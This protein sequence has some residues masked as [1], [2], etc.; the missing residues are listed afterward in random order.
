MI[1]FIC[2]SQTGLHW[3]FVLGFACFIFYYLVI[4]S[5]QHLM[6]SAPFEM[7]D[8]DESCTDAKFQQKIKESVNRMIDVIYTCTFTMWAGMLLFNGTNDVVSHAYLYVLSCG[9]FVY[10]TFDQYRKL[11]ICFA[12]NCSGTSGLWL[13]VLR[14]IIGALMTYMCL[15]MLTVE[16]GGWKESILSMMVEMTASE[17]WNND[18]QHKQALCKHLLNR[19][20]KVTHLMTLFLLLLTVSWVCHAYRRLVQYTTLNKCDFVCDPGKYICEYKNTACLESMNCIPSPKETKLG[21]RFLLYTNFLNAFFFAGMIGLLVLQQMF[22]T[23]LLNESKAFLATS[24]AHYVISLIFMIRQAVLFVNLLDENCPPPSP[25]PSD[26][27]K[28]C[29]SKRKNSQPKKCPS[30]AKSPCDSEPAAASTCS[31]PKSKSTCKSTPK[32]LSKS[33]SKST[34][35]SATKS[36]SRTNSKS[37]SSSNRDTKS[38][39]R[40]SKCKQEKAQNVQP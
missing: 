14:S 27:G 19:E 26:C 11:T 7:D 32:Q 8:V 29:A 30:T 6:A 18:G 24:T 15:R 39:P 5:V 17:R 12:Q 40:E 10:S 36:T 16:I 25:S 4:F 31:R 21:N 3:I 33:T 9:Y 22:L 38:K 23:P 13:K 34:C 37:K 2:L 20:S 28:V 1:L 35:K